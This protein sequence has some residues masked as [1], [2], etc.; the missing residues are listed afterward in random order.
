VLRWRA[1]R[2]SGE[3]AAYA[4]R[5]EDYIAL[6]PRGDTIIDGAMWPV[7]A[8]EQSEAALRGLE[9]S[10]DWAPLGRVVVGARGD[11]ARLRFADGAPIPFA[12]APRLGASLRWEDERLAF[13]TGVRHVFA[14]RA[15]AGGG[16]VATAAY[17][18]ADADVGVRFG[19]AADHSITVRVTNLFDTAFRD[20]A[21]RTKWFAPNPGRNVALLYRIHF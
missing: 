20:A 12:P 17:T 14:Q 6:V 11:I 19:P 16:D 3:L 1:A 2:L 10:I 15:T 13:G 7:L 9:G 21:S 4:A 18:L 8:Y 5:V